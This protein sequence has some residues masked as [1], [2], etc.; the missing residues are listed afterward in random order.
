MVPMA[1]DINQLVGKRPR[2]NK[3]SDRSDLND[4]LGQTPETG[5]L[6]APTKPPPSPTPTPQPKKRQTGL[7]GSGVAAPSK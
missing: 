3:T 5:F 7:E 4:M 6:Q 2:P 1:I